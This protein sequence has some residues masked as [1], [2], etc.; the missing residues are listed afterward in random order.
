[1]ARCSAVTLGVTPNQCAKPGSAEYDHT[2]ALGVPPRMDVVEAA[3]D[4][5]P[6][7]VAADQRVTL[8]PDRVDG[9]DL[10][11]GRLTPIDQAE[12]YLLVR[13]RDVAADE[14]VLA[15]SAE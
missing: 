7:G 13:E 11:S 1:M 15:Q 9:T 8:V 10:V 2:P 6:V 14:S 3:D 5:K 12:R 4:A